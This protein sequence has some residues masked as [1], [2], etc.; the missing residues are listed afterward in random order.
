MKMYRFI[1]PNNQTKGMD[2]KA[3][4]LPLNE[5]S[6]RFWRKFSESEF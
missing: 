1:L 6:G 3:K 4:I 5:E 2:F